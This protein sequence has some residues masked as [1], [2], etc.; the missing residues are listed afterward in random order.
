MKHKADEEV[1]S[2]TSNQVLVSLEDFEGKEL[3]TMFEGDFEKSYTLFTS[4]PQA[5]V[6]LAQH[7]PSQSFG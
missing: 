6:Q 3:N 4:A 1:S 5:A 2:S 7:S